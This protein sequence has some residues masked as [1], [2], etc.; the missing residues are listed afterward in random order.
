M[1]LNS[2]SRAGSGSFCLPRSPLVLS[3]FPVGT[4]GV[5]RFDSLPRPRSRSDRPHGLGL[6]F[7]VLSRAPAPPLGGA[8][9][10]EIRVRPSSDI[11][12]VRPLPGASSLR[13]GAATRPARSALV[14]SHQP[15][16][17]P[18]L[19]GLRV[20]CAPLPD[21]GSP[22]FLVVPSRARLERR[23]DPRFLPRDAFHTL[24]R[25]PL[26]D[27]QHHITVACCP[28]VVTGAADSRMQSKPHSTVAPDQWS[29]C[30]VRPAL[31]G[32]WRSRKPRPSFRIDD[33]PIRRSG[34][35]RHP[36]GAAAG[37]NQQLPAVPP[38]FPGA[39][40]PG[41]PCGQVP[42]ESGCPRQAQRRNPRPHPRAGGEPSCSRGC[43]ALRRAQPD[44]RGGLADEPVERT[45][46][47]RLQGFAPPTSPWCH[48]AV[49]SDATLDHSMGF[50]PLQG[51]SVLAPGP[52][53]P[54]LTSSGVPKRSR[55]PVASAAWRTTR[56]TTAGIPLAISPRPPRRSAAAGTELGAET[57]TERRAFSA[58]RPAPRTVR[59]ALTRRGGV[60]NDAESR[61]SVRNRVGEQRI[62][63]AT[64]A[65]NRP[66]ATAARREP[67]GAT[68]RPSWGFSDVKERS[69]E[70]S[71][72]SAP[73][74]LL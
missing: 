39:E 36:A 33:A 67:R 46:S 44:H 20:C 50:V 38:F 65:A 51:P 62:R 9:S 57:E 42:G 45:R 17:F 70:R 28:L 13:H 74:L 10:R 48:F 19:A 18:P 41:M 11:P 49:A 63:D 40:A 69:E 22:R 60:E 1:L 32:G 71:P 14:V 21:Q 56:F 52:G 6:H 4:P 31:R 25:V 61:E 15:R 58:R 2:N 43:R 26:A 53:M 59:R 23:R 8:T 27:S 64:F 73:A 68:H 66:R 30:P 3:P 72:R 5:S 12:N 29:G 24:R 47:S 35:P 34:P 16:R 55:T 54:R 7:E 37:R